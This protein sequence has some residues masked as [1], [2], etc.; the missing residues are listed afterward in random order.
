MTPAD[1]ARF[2]QLWQQGASYRALA[3]ALGCAEGTVGSR[4]YALVRQ[5]KIQP[6]PRGGAHPR[7]RTPTPVQR[8]VQTPDTGAV[9]PFDTGAVQ[10]LDPYGQITRNRKPFIKFK[11]ASPAA[12]AVFVIARVPQR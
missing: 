7:Q 6:R 10:R 4:A 11:V 2:I 8:P 1:E 9:R 3:Q 5:E 12:S